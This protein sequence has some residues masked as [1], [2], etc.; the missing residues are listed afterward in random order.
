[1]RSFP[2]RGAIAASFASF[3]VAAVPVLAA[4]VEVVVENAGFE[5]PVLDDGMFGLGGVAPW[6]DFDAFGPLNPPEFMPILNGPVPEG[7][8]VA[9]SNLSGEDCAEQILDVSLCEDDVITLKVMVGARNDALMYGGYQVALQAVAPDDSRYELAYASSTDGGAVAPAAGEFIEVTLSAPVKDNSYDGYK[10]AVKLGS[11]ADGTT[12]Q[13]LFDDVRVDIERTTLHVPSCYPTIQDA[14]NAA[15][16]GDLVLIEEGT[17]YE[18]IDYLGKDII[19]RGDCNGDK[20]D[21]T[22]FKGYCVTITRP[23]I[24]MMRGTL[25]PPLVTFNSGETA[26]AVLEYVNLDGAYV[27]IMMGALAFIDG[28]SP[29]FNNV[30]FYG[31]HA[32]LYGGAVWIEKGA[33]HFYDCEF[34][35]NFAS[36]DGGA[37]WVGRQGSPN[38]YGCD[39]YENYS[40]YG[41]GGA[42]YV[43]PFG[44]LE[45]IECDFDYN[46]ALTFGGALCLNTFR[47]TWVTDC[48]FYEN[49]ALVGGAASSRDGSPMFMYC[50]FE[51]NE[52]C[53]DGGAYF[54]YDC[55]TMFYESSFYG[56]DSEYCGNNNPDRGIEGEV[57]GGAIGHNLGTL[58]VEHCY[59]E[60]NYS[61]GYYGG[62]AIGVRGVQTTVLDSSFYRNIAFDD[63]GG[64]I[65]AV[66]GFTSI[67]R[68]SFEQ[69]AVTSDLRWDGGDRVGGGV[70]L[71]YRGIDIPRGA[72]GDA[73]P[74][75][76][77]INSVFKDNY[78][79]V[80][81]GGTYIDGTGVD[82]VNCTYY[83]NETDG[84]QGPGARGLPPFGGGIY[85]HNSGSLDINIANNIIWGNFPDQIFN[86][87]EEPNGGADPIVQYNDIEGG[88]PGSGFNDQGGNIDEYPLFVQVDDDLECDLS[89]RGNSPCIDAAN[90]PVLEGVKG[91]EFDIDLN[92]RVLDDTGTVDTGVAGLSGY[93]VDMGAYEFQGTS[94]PE[95]V[96]GCNDA[97]LAEPYDVLD[98]S[99]VSAFLVAF[100]NADDMADMAPDYGVMDY[101]DV[102]MFLQTFA[103]GC[104]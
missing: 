79:E 55:D 78:A 77:I 56:N 8:N 4:P 104:P 63:A 33:S 66:D 51:H 82:V 13:T 27:D 11:H 48:Y 24:E 58:S 73:M 6:S 22:E 76:E 83:S 32:D 25:P 45:L 31:G 103:E 7:S 1:M 50:G 3:A 47:Q 86:P 94:E 70:A 54:G 19:V 87:A 39:F 43:A 91:E 53:G 81:G 68:S 40:Q 28:A 74:L 52:A 26:D 59:F 61:E 99:D 100:A 34:I 46:Q 62:G 29:T 23:E 89:L 69:N 20:D 2:S 10:L 42:I 90:T 75:G 21:G 57:G 97:D 37:V 49:Y 95:P 17:Y 67:R 15:E 96:L 16:D 5:E 30:L 84:P 101:S 93:V 102:L 72:N 14:I 41:G 85:A 38:F 36:L 35:Y 88:V 18:V 44:G 98:Y 80:A 12:T 60:Y 9:F 64:G 65:N 92:D 71:R